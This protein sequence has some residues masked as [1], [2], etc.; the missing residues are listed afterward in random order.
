MRRALIAAGVVLAAV[1]AVW[2]LRRTVLAPA[3][4]AVRVVAVADGTV[5][6]TVANSRAGTVKARRRAELSPEVGGV[7][8]ALPHR[9]GDRVAAG[10]VVMQL[11]SR[12]QDAQQALAQGQLRA[13]TAQ[14]AQ[15]C[16]SAERAARER[17]RQTY[18]AKVG[19]ISAD[20]LDQTTTE[21]RTAAAACRAADAGIQEA[22]ASLDLASRQLHQTVLRA[23]FDGII[24]RISTEVGEFTTPSPPGLPIPPVIDFIDPA[25]IYVSAPVDEADSARVQPGQAVRLTLDAFRGRV[26]AGRVRRVAPFV[27]DREEQNRTLDI[28]IDP[29][30][31]PGVRLLPGTSADA[32]V[33]VSTRSHVLRVPTAALLEGDQV[34]CISGGRAVPHRLRIGIR[35]WD[36][37]EILSG[38]A[39]GD[40]VIVSLDRPEV[41]AGA[42]VRVE[43]IGAAPAGGPAPP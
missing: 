8:V 9:E 36:W 17:D 32:E 2:G 15:S 12:V 28:E 16:L 22:T 29:L 7:V 21:A 37:S 25:S 42:R 35:N 27:Q 40:Q 26:F 5:E 13:A 4:A 34:L 1:A 19:A 3:P 43:G 10:E 6:E 18:L 31:P 11:K 38:V 33:I 20:A 14:R 23:P 30:L 39:A 24:A 41:K